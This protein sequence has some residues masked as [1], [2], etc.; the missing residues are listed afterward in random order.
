MKVR[1]T[2]FCP[3]SIEEMQA[4]HQG[5]FCPNCNKN[6]IDF[7]Q[8]S[9][10]EIEIYLEEAEKPVCGVILKNQFSEEKIIGRAK[11]RKKHIFCN[12]VFIFGL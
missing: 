10:E 7:R 11:L 8:K 5:F 2:K 3:K 4:T 9:K 6:V 12:S 1:V